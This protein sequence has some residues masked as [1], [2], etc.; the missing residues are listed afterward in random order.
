MKRDVMNYTYVDR[1]RGD[2]YGISR[3]ESRSDLSHILLLPFIRLREC[4]G[5]KM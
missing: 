4:H 5:I 3:V 1:A 2:R